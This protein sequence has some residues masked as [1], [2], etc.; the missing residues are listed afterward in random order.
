MLKANCQIRNRL[1]AGHYQ[2][3]IVRGLSALVLGA[4]V[5]GMI[6]P[7]MLLLLNPSRLADGG[8]LNLALFIFVCAC[9]VWALGLTFLAAPI[10]FVLDRIELRSIWVAMLLGSVL[11]FGSVFVWKTGLLGLFLTP[12]HS[13]GQAGQWTIDRGR[14][15]PYGW[16]LA[17]EIGLVF[18]IQGAVVGAVVWRCAYR[19]GAA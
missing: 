12:D 5:G 16:R 7:A 18:A 9:L 11:C 2:T 15:T 19:R 8:L 1:E 14:L 13:E 3:D 17:A 10:W 6:F 4:L